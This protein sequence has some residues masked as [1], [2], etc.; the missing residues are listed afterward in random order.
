METMSS[1]SDHRAV[2]TR[3]VTILVIIALVNVGYP[4]LGQESAPPNSPRVSIAVS[5]TECAGRSVIPAW[6]LPRSIS[7]RRMRL[8]IPPGPDKRPLMGLDSRFGFEGDFDISVD[9]SIRSL[10]RPAKEWVNLLPSSSSGRM[11]WP[12]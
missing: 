11:A 4:V 5:S 10:P 7:R 2:A 6:P 9:Y 8:V 3:N 1:C 12:R